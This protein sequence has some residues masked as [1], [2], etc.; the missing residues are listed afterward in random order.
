MASL[1]S[2]PGLVW[3][4]PRNVIAAPAGARRRSILAGDMA[5]RRPPHTW[6][7]ADR[8]GLTRAFDQSTQGV[9]TPT[10]QFYA[11]NH[12]VHESYRM[13]ITDDVTLAEREDTLA[14]AAS[15]RN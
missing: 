5:A 6:E 15:R 10:S 7:P 11:K 9:D 13:K 12:V 4:P 1:S 14:P 3:L 2:E 8:H